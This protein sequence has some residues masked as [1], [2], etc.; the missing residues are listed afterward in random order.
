MATHEELKNPAI[1]WVTDGEAQPAAGGEADSPETGRHAALLLCGAP[2]SSPYIG[3]LS[4]PHGLIARWTA[5]A[6]DAGASEKEKLACYETYGL[7]PFG[8]VWIAGADRNGEGLHHWRKLGVQAGRTANKLGCRSLTVLLPGEDGSAVSLEE[9]IYAVTEGL[10][11]GQYRMK[12]YRREAKEEERDPALRDIELVLGGPEAERLARDPALAERMVRLGRVLAEATNAARDWTNLPGN[13]LSPEGLAEEARKLAA[14]YPRLECDVIDERRARELGM[15]GLLAVGQGSERPPRMIVLTYRGQSER[16]GVTGL[17]G[18]GIT[19]DTGGISLKKAEGMEEMI[20]DMGGAAV[21]LGV[22]RG[23][24]ELAPPI[25][26]AA[27]IPAAE[28]MPSGSAY[29]PGDVIVTLDGRTV[30]VLNTDAE[31]RIV[32]ADGVA[33]AKRLGAERLIEVSTLTGAVLTVLGDA[34]TAAV[35][36]DEA[37]LA[38]LLAATRR[39]GERIWQLPAYPEYKDMI[40]S[41]VA[42]VKNSTSPRWAGV[43]TA[44]LF[45]G[46]FADDTP[47]IHLDTGGTAWLWGERAVDPKGGTGALVR[48]LLHLLCRPLPPPDEA[49]A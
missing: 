20:S 29:R 26:V 15:G 8:H 21:L 13:L 28:N 18:K 10:L 38:E 24:A 36:N 46:T 23:L 22:M 44:G 9:T 14:Q 3:R 30:E 40:K 35:T 7:L 19:F 12:T 27:V 33:Y 32:L 31:G 37:Y 25:N 41:T 42:D 39:S 17:V 47:W 2:E 43:I 48:T 6:K 1:R 45:I 34:A 5:K 11:L 4:D 16:S 49:R